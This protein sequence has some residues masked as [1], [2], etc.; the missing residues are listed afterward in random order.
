M[1]WGFDFLVKETVA[2]DLH[3]INLRA[4]LW[5]VLPLCW[6]SAGPLGGGEMVPPLQFCA[7]AVMQPAFLRSSGMLTEV[8][9]DVTATYSCHPQ[10]LLPLQ[11]WPKTIRNCSRNQTLTGSL[12]SK[13]HSEHV[14]LTVPEARGTPWREPSAHVSQEKTMTE[15]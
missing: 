10:I 4:F 9:V 5:L 3:E 12:A 14:V 8:S 1:C 6:A 2:H 7:H 13:K 11:Q 15:R